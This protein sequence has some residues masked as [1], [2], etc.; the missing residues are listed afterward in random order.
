MNALAKSNFS[1]KEEVIKVAS[2]VYSNNIRIK[3]VTQELDYFS[4]ACWNMETPY[5]PEE[6]LYKLEEF[7]EPSIFLPSW[8]TMLPYKDGF[9]IFKE[10]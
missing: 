4:S 5:C 2:F 8:K 10:D 1:Q 6:T 7:T 9:R 3:A